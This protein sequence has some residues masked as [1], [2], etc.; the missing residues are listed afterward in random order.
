M[1]AFTLSATRRLLAPAVGAIA[2]VLLFAY[3]SRA[4]LWEPHARVLPQ[5]IA[6][7]TF[8]LF[9]FLLL[10]AGGAAFARVAGR[11]SWVLRL[12]WATALVVAL[13]AALP[14]V[15][16]G[17]GWAIVFTCRAAP[18]C[19]QLASEVLDGFFWIG[20]SILVW[21]ALPFIVAPT[22]LAAAAQPAQRTNNAL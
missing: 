19:G 3:F 9:A 10:A 7:S 17:L 6:L 8:G 13:T 4:P 15:Q 12:M 20:R 11:A 22:L 14:F 18:I 2:V 1:E 5:A 16:V 21:L